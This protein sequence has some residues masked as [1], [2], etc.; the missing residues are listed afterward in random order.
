MNGA[1]KKI[2]YFYLFDLSF[3]S[4]SKPDT[5]LQERLC[6]IRYAHGSFCCLNFTDNLVSLHPNFTSTYKFRNYHNCTEF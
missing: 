5:K 2:I 1:E 4:V 3:L 6:I